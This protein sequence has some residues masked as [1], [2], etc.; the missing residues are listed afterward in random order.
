MRHFILTAVI[1]SASILAMAQT[2]TVTHIVQR[3]ETIE[4]IAEY[5]HVSIDDINKANPNTEGLVYVGMKLMVPVK[6]DNKITTGKESLA[7]FKL[8]SNISMVTDAEKSAK[9]ESNDSEHQHKSI[10][11]K[12][13]LADF[14]VYGVNYRASFKD[15]GHGFYGLGGYAFSSSGFGANFS[16]GAD[17]GLVN[18]DYAGICFY[19]GPSYAYALNNVLFMA[20]LDYVG[21]YLGTGNSEKTG[22]NHKGETYTYEGNDSKYSWGIAFSPSVGIKINKFTP[23]VGLDFNWSKDAKKID[24]GFCAGI[25]FDI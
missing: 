3:G 24:V 6:E 16:I 5:Y 21:T 4:S 13:D 23:Y 8:P 14:H 20:S 12:Q 17:Y 9:I 22:T 15:A 7:A 1:S 2:S 10:N 25:G 19:I 18:K 11:I